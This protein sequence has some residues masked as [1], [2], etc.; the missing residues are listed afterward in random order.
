MSRFL[1]ILLLSPQAYMDNAYPADELMPLS[2]KG[3]WRGSEVSRGD[4]DDAL[5]N[6][7]LTLVDS[8]DTLFVLGDFDEFERGVQLI[9]RD[10]HF[11]RDIIGKLC[12]YY[13]ILLCSNFQHLFQYLCLRPTFECLVACYQLTSYLAICRNIIHEC[14]G[15][16]GSSWI[17][18]QILGI[19]SYLHST[20]QRESHTPRSTLKRVSGHRNW[21]IPRRL[22][23]LAQEQWS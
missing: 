10:V 13:F 18:P 6:F 20:P 19:G 2:C 21:A 17:W 23:L 15:T 5:G 4:V 7:S 11:D 8:V 22:V 12:W 1:L 14:S 3:R 16:R 9:L